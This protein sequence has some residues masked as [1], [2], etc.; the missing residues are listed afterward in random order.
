MDEL[1][2]ELLSIFMLAYMKHVEEGVKNNILSLDQ[3][4]KMFFGYL[5]HWSLIPLTL[6]VATFLFK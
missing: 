2:K 1:I 6:V 3:S 5:F 4:V